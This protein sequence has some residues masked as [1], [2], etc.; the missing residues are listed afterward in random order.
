MIDTHCHLDTEAFDDDRK[1]VLERAFS[2]GVEAIVIPSIEPQHFD[3]VRA[4]V[5]SSD[6]IYCGV[7]VH[8]HNAAEVTEETFQLIEKS[9]DNE[10]T[11]AVG[12]IGLDY[13]YDFAP[14]DVQQT[15]LRRQL[16]IAKE[17]G[18]PVILHNRESDDDM[19]SLLRE[20]QDGSLRGVLHCFSGTPEMARQALDL[21]MMLSFTGN[22]TYK[23][24]TL[25][26]TVQAV[27]LERIMIETDAPY[28]TPVPH[29][30]RRNE[31]AFV[32]FIAEKIAELHSVSLDE[33][34]SM[35]TQTAK[36]FFHLALLMLL[37]PLVMQAQDEDDI[38][39]EEGPRF[40]K[41][42]GIGAVL[43]T[44]TIV[45]TPEGGGDISYD[46]LFAYGGVLSYH[47]TPEISVEASIMYSKN[48]KVLT[49]QALPNTHTVLDLAAIYNFKPENRLSFFAAL[50]PSYFINNYNGERET[51]TG[52]NFGVGLLGNIETGVGLFSPT[53]E[54]RVSTMLGSR[55]RFD[56][57]T[58]QYIVV[59]FFSS[60]PRFKLLWFPPI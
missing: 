49:E 48:N 7:G 2:S 13:Y 4:L 29:R 33:V 46:G 31:P 51:L 12:E 23:K 36:R 60:I 1:D 20:E 11:V 56:V 6:R 59:N 16:R 22:I 17:R 50:G 55:E 38:E 53:L 40:L 42:L 44:N 37:V 41:T 28:M 35:T 32:R 34:L 47:F 5:A 8:P 21:G 19:L 54:W 52:L 9:L 27:P 10:R 26:P 25:G 24:S 43:G 57:P 15:V 14:R 30:G 45:E 58:N 18:L 39:V 3:R